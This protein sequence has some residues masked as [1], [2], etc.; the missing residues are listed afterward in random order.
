MLIPYKMIT[1]RAVQWVKQHKKP[2]A[3]A[4][5]VAAVALWA[6]IPNHAPKQAGQ[7]AA[8]R[9]QSVI[10][11]CSKGEV[12]FLWQLAHNDLHGHQDDYLGGKI[13]SGGD[14][15]T[16]GSPAYQSAQVIYHFWTDVIG[17]SGAFAAGIL[18]NLAVESGF[19]P[20]ISQG[21]GRFAT[22]LSKQP[23]RNVGGGGG[24]YQFTPYS[25]Y[26]GSGEWLGII[27]PHIINAALGD[28]SGV[29]T[30]IQPP[31]ID[32][33]YKA[34]FA[35]FFASP[36]GWGIYPQSWYVWDHD[37][38]DGTTD[39]FLRKNNY[40][41]ALGTTTPLFKGFI[42]VEATPLAA[43]QLAS[44]Q[45]TKDALNFQVNLD[46]EYM[47]TTLDPKKAADAFLTT[48]ERPA[49]YQPIRAQYAI[50]ANKL[51]NKNNFPGDPVKLRKNLP[52]G[53]T[54]IIQT[55]NTIQNF[56]DFLHGPRHLAVDDILPVVDAFKSPCRLP[57]G[58][59]VEGLVGA[60]NFVKATCKLDDTDS[61]D[62]AASGGGDSSGAAEDSAESSNIGGA[63]KTR[64]P[65]VTVTSENG[66]DP[67][68]G[69]VKIR[70]PEGA[71]ENTDVQQWLAANKQRL[72]ITNVTTDPTDPGVI[73]VTYA[74]PQPPSEG[75]DAGSR[76][77]PT[78]PKRHGLTADPGQFIVPAT[79]VVS[80]GFGWR[81]AP[82][83]GA[84]SFHN[85]IDIANK[86]GTPIYAAG[87][88]KVVLAGPAR[89]YGNWVRIQHPDGT[90]TQYGHMEKI[91][92]HVGAEVKTGDLIALMGH[93]G[94]A[95]GPHLDF[96]V[97]QDGRDIDPFIFFK[98]HGINVPGGGSKKNEGFHLTAGRDE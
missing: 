53:I 1:R 35:D 90:Y 97:H 74:Q 11:P 59:K 77:C 67:T 68:V 43:A 5:V 79:G 6:A 60:L 38:T 22:V 28:M 24:L 66:A 98:E 9:Y 14:W 51:F 56:F 45:L 82:V 73:A 80:S 37:L 63:V 62:S 36:V 94:A 42:H 70:L 93:E 34:A 76:W 39:A 44:G 64:F 55:T 25:K 78:Q 27:K 17:T 31:T 47:A 20:N 3:G 40:A 7:E 52:L 86:D 89:G 92:T 8:A 85:A 49:V 21:G 91:L 83:A 88:G 23:D 75:V 65:G 12:E 16:P 72:K 69:L 84:T 71:E 13:T 54:N 50:L 30:H 10:R 61:G 4:A 57:G 18:G 32:S 81:V 48:Y 33:T 15:T 26:T 95:T 58:R 46:P 41:A 96:V 2:V 87:S 29:D 19:V